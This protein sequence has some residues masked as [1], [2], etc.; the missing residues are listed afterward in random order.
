MYTV[1]MVIVL[2]TTENEC[3]DKNREGGKRE[4]EHQAKSLSLQRRQDEEMVGQ[5]P[6]RVFQMSQKDVV[7]DAAMLTTTI[8]CVRCLQVVYVCVGK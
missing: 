7:Y 3:I 2:Q 6:A 1:V 8:I 4:K 5:C